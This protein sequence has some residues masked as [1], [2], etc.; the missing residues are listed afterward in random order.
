MVG[1]VVRLLI[2]VVACLF[3]TSILAAQEKTP[4]DRLLA[5][6]GQYYTP[7]T[8]GLKSFQCGAAIDWKATL[9]RLSGAEIPEDNPVLKYLQGVNLSVVDQLKGKGSME[10]TDTVVPPEGKEEAVKQMRDGLQE[11]MGG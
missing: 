6:H 10:W 2:F 5:A 8:S 4:R 11:M 9:T 1:K 3:C 7:T